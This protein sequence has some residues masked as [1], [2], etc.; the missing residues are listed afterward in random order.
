MIFT[1]AQ[2]MIRGR[3]KLLEEEPFFGILALR[4]KIIDDS[5]NT[6]SMATDGRSI[7]YN[8]A[9]VETLTFLHILGVIAHEILHCA[10]LHMY[11]RKGRDPKRWNYACDY[12]I[13]L[14]LIDHFGFSLPEPFLYDKRYEG[15]SAE[16]IYNRLPEDCE[17]LPEDPSE[18]WGTFTDASEDISNPSGSTVAEQERIWETDTKVAAMSAGLKPGSL[19]APFLKALGVGQAKVDWRKQ[20]AQ[21]VGAISQSDY[22][23]YPPHP[24][25][26]SQ[27][28]HVPTLHAPSIGHL[29]YAIDRS[30]SMLQRYLNNCTTEINQLLSNV[31]FEGVTVLICDTQLH[32]KPIEFEEGEEMD[33]NVASGG[34]T[35]FMPVFDYIQDHPTDALIYFTDME[36]W[37]HRNMPPPSYPVFWARTTDIEPPFGQCI[38]LFREAA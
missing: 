15:L 18:V 12:A 1:T 28:L 27:G 25:Y 2:K 13:N 9:W 7:F 11:R 6:Q 21:V 35:S 3:C 32:G 26:L 5:D 10:F 22:A 4:L 17:G 8:A 20:L 23:W 29:T 33:F 37:D 19:A 14:L 34:G 31:H 16:E 30:A 36:C 24:I 38:D